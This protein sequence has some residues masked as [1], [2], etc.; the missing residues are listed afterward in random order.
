MFCRCEDFSR[1]VE[2]A[3]QPATLTFV[4]TLGG[5]SR[6]LRQ[7]WEP[8]QGRMACDG[9]CRWSKIRDP[10]A[11]GRPVRG[12]LRNHPRIDGLRRL[13]QRAHPHGNRR[14]ERLRKVHAHPILRIRGPRPA[15]GSRCNSPRYES[16]ESKGA[17]GGNLATLC[18]SHN[19]SE[20]SLA[21]GKLQ[22]IAA[23]LSNQL[24]Y[25]PIDNTAYNMSFYQLMC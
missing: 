20:P 22:S 2:Q 3:F 21:C 5:I 12:K 4:S 16:V 18:C 9:A 7:H 24:M 1:P 19:D 23:S 6:W 13:R 17:S 14:P 25:L 11:A 15:A 10:L 8:R